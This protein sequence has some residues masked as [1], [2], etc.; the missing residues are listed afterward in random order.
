MAPHNLWLE[1]PEQVRLGEQL[2]CRICYGHHF[3]LDG[4]VD[5]A[6]V[7]LDVYARGLDHLT[8]EPVPR[9]EVLVASFIPETTGMHTIVA[10]FDAGVYSI[11]PKGKHYPGGREQNTGHKVVRTVHYVHYAKKIITVERETPLP[12]SFGLEYEIIPFSI[13]DGDIEG[14]VQYNG[15]P[16]PEV[17]VFAHGRN[18]P[19]SRMVK[20][21]HDGRFELH[22][23]QGEWMLIAAHK[24]PGEEGIAD[25]RHIASTFVL[26]L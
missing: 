16:L 18:K 9:D 19:M 21:R 8:L 3:T 6:K 26:T 1:C 11:D 4:K 22:L 25:I 23:S 10:K 12:G 13:G 20:T 15:K 17:T 14:L 7:S 5:P 2:F 24:V